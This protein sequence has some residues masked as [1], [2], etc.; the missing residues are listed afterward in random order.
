VYLANE[1]RVGDTSVPYSVVAALDPAAKPP[2]GPFLPDGL[3]SLR[4]DEIVL[5]DWPGSPLKAKIGDPVTLT[6][7]SRKRSRANRRSVR[8]P[9]GSRASSACRAADDPDLT[10]EFPGIT[11]KTDIKNW[12]PPFPYDPERIKKTDEEYWEK[13]RTTPKAYITLA[14][15]QKLW[16]TRFGSLTSIRLA[17]EDVS[18]DRFAGWL[19]EEL[20]PSTGGFVFDAVRTRALES[21]A[22]FMDFGSLFLGFSFFLI[23]AALLLVGLLFRLNLDRRASQIGLLLALGHTQRTV[24]RLLLAEG[25]VLAAVGCLLGLAG[26]VGYAWLMLR[27]LRSWW[28]G[29]LDGSFLQLHLGEDCGRSFLIGFA[30]TFL[31]SV[32]TIAW[33]VFA[34]GRV[35]PRAAS[36][37]NGRG[38]RR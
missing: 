14:A 38:Q 32:L 22:G 33:A 18:A 2:L 15:G 37:R 10:P 35:A 7:L 34:L 17:G 23:A 28:P 3:K 29:G 30:A 4:D 26:A 36:G 8:R 24:R 13:H 11:D 12:D 21:S 5:V 27:L 19:R 20:K 16:E 25:A 1:I 31:V 9:S 6:F